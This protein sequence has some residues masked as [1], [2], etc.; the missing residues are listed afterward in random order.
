M[1]SKKIL[2]AEDDA[3]F[4]NVLKQYLEL[5]HYEVF[6]AEKAR[7]ATKSAATYAVQKLLESKFKAIKGWDEYVP[8]DVR[9]KVI[10]AMEVSVASIG[11]L[12]FLD[13]DKDIIIHVGE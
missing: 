2:L 8:A 10:G 1:Q 3:D 11:D 12:V 9:Y 13:S 7:G 5:H 4:A 6:W